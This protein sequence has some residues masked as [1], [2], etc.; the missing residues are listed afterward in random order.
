M[1]TPFNPSFGQYI[2]SLN[3]TVAGGPVDKFILVR[4]THVVQ[5]PFLLGTNIPDKYYKDPTNLGEI[6]FQILNTVQDSTLQSDGN[7]KTAKPIFAG[8]KQYP[9]EGELVYVVPG[10][11]SAL[12]ENK[13]IRDLFYFPPYNLWSNS[14]HNAIPDLGD[15][16]AYVNE[17]KRTYQE[18]QTTRQSNNLSATGSENFPLGP[19]FPE[20]FNIKSLRQFTG[21]VTVETTLEPGCIATSKTIS[22]VI[23]L[24]ISS[25]V[26]RS[27][28]FLL[29]A[30]GR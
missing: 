22:V 12:N 13:G 27:S 10:P 6:T 2:S 19:N 20:K 28:T 18:S 29:L 15:Y 4:V 3:S 25:G 11:S 5:G 16:S 9:L 14:H 24:I 8:F 17:Q 23:A 30:H 21:D 1:S 26:L 7:A